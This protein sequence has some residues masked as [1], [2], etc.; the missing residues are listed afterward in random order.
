MRYRPP[1]VCDVC[2]MQS[3]VR[4]SCPSCGGP[5]RDED[6]NEAPRPRRFDERLLPSGGLRA[7]AVL[8]LTLWIGATLTSLFVLLARG[9]RMPPMELGAPE[10][11]LGVLFSLM[12]LPPIGYAILSAL[13]GRRLVRWEADQDARLRARAEDAGELRSIETLADDEPVRFVGRV[14]LQVPVGGG[15]AALHDPDDSRQVGVF[16]VLDET[17][18]ALVDDDCLEL[19]GQTGGVGQALEVRDGDA[20]E[21]IGRGRWGRGAHGAGTSGYRDGR[22]FVLEGGPDAPLLLRADTDLVAH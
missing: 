11:W 5:M 6:G 19:F 7:V 4:A 20:V 9:D 10:V 12:L 1:F 2:S 15:L 3:P 17:G 14:S 8:G 21:V 16:L 18:A 22:V 13:R